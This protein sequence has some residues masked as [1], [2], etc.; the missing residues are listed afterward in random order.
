MK[1]PA[2]GQDAGKT[3]GLRERHFRTLVENSPDLIT[4]FDHECRTLY[5]NPAAV[6]A[7]GARTG[8]FLGATH[9]ELGLPAIMVASSE[10]T[11]RRVFETGEEQI[12]E[13]AVP[14]PEGMKHYL[15]RG[16]P[17]YGE[18]GFIESALVIHRDI[19]AHKMAEKA[20]RESEK[21]Y[22]E[23]FAAARRQATEIELLD[24]VR[25]ALAGELEL[26]VVFRTVVES[27]AAS[28]GYTQV[29]I[30]LLQGDVLKCQHQV[31]YAHVIQEMPMTRGIMGRVARTGEAALVEDVR[32]DP[33]FIGAIEGIVSEV[34]IPLLDQA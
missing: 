2:G 13:M 21:H 32:T 33:D 31:G 17:E 14:G 11:I 9:S 26:P 20:L 24:R 29:S 34:C 19:T 27:T 1:T 22:Q 8:A 4:R 15:A 5:A 3:V 7:L 12:F 10:A 16:V 28:F 6:K 18:D 30:Y 23:L 25:T